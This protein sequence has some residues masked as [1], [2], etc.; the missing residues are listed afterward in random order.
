MRLFE[1]FY[2]TYAAK[3]TYSIDFK[4]LW[5]EGFRGVIFDI[6]N[7]LV[8]H[9]Q[10][11]DR[12][13]YKFLKSLKEYGFRTMI[14]SNNEEPRVKSFADKLECPYVY[15]ALKPRGTGYT[16]A[17]ELMDLPCDQIICIGDQ[18]FTDIW[19]ANRA[20]MKSV[21]V[22]RL[23]YKEPPHIHFK[24]VL[25]FP[26]LHSYFRKRRREAHAKSRKY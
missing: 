10:P 23:F 24:R 6:D 21:L 25:E 12:R 16:K 7:T 26:V 17:K 22:G 5:D 9:D 4:K 19:G 8:G 1:G 18:L 20:G 13:A 2:P 15:K 11:A 3:N 14:V